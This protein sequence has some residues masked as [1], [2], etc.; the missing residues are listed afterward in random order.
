M[1]PTWL[2]RAG[3]WMTALPASRR[4]TGYHPS[5]SSQAHP[6]GTVANK[7]RHV[8]RGN[9]VLRYGVGRDLARCSQVPVS[10]SDSQT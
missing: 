8:S 5:H 3:S 4:V 2:V 7:D 9:R 6:T 10:L 1:L